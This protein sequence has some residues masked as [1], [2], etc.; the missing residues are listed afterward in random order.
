MNYKYFNMGIKV[1]VL[2]A[3]ALFF[4]AQS[5][6]A[7][8]ADTTR[9][10]EI[11]EVVVVAYG[12]QK[13]ETFVGSNVTI[14]AK[15]IEDRPITNAAKALDGAGAGIQVS[16]SSGQPGS[17]ISVRIRG[18]SSYNLSNSPLYVIDGAI[19]TGSINDL[20]PSDI[21]SL[22]VLKDAASTSLYGA[23][24]ANGIV[25][26][27][28]KSGR[29]GKSKFEFSTSTGFVSRGYKDYDRIGTKDYYE[30]QWL[31]LRNGYMD[32]LTAPVGQA[33]ANQRA[34]TNLIPTLINNV[35][36]VPNNQLVV[37]GV[38]NPNAQ[39]LFDD[40]DWY[41]YVERT[42]VI[43]KYNINYGGGDERTQYYAS[44]GYNK[45]EGYAIKSQFERYNVRVDAN[46][47]V[48]D[49]LKLGANIAA[50]TSTTLFANDSGGTS[51]I[52]PFYTARSMAPIY[53]P[54][55]YDANGQRVKDSDGNDIYDGIIT[56]GRTSGSGRNVIQETLLND[57]RTFKDVINT[58]L[59]AEFNLYKGLTL[60]TNVS[61]DL[62]NSNNKAYRNPIIGDALGTG[63]L[64]SYAYRYQTLTLNQIL[65]YVKSF[66]LH[67]IDLT[68][69]HESFGYNSSFSG[70]GRRGQIV[71]GINE[72]INFTNL[73]YGG[74]SSSDLRKESYFG[75][76]NYDYANK[77][78]VTASL[79]RDSSSR[80]A[81]DNDTGIFWSV[82]AGW[83]IANESFMNDSAFNSLK[84]R[85]SYG[86][87]G[88][89]GG[90]G[91]APG[92][93]ADLNLYNLGW[94]NASEN[95]ILI[96]QVGNKDL[97]WESNKQF[98]VAVDFGLYNNRISG[99]FEYYK[100][101]T[102]DMIFAV[103]VPMSSGIRSIYYNIGNSENEGVEATLNLGLVRSTDFTWDFSVN[104][105]HYTNKMTKMPESQSVISSGNYRIENGRSLNDFYLRQWYG[106]DS[107]DGL[108]LFVQDSE[109]TDNATT[110]TM[111]DG[112]KVTTD[113][114][115]A[116]FDYSGSAIP[117]V[118][119]SFTNRFT[120]KGFYLDALFTYQ[121]GGKLYDSNYA[122]LMSPNPNG[123]AAHVDILKSWKNPGDITDVPK[124]TTVNTVNATAA[125]SR[126]LV[127]SDY[128]SLRQ[129]TLGY[130]VNKD[131]IETIGLVGLKLFVSGENLWAKTAKKGL[132][133]IQSFNGTTS[134]RYIPSRIVSVGLNATF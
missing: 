105:S 65:N 124:L 39:L 11:E 121:W 30:T 123:S 44:M 31:S 62:Q 76:A 78:I 66:G 102:A 94:N 20:D 91:S 48:T 63:D 95:G 35:Y 46:S 99:T 86:E 50:S 58:R 45:E 75:R 67:N 108:A 131:Y 64:Y 42:G 29:K 57:D 70:V 26:I 5:A 97:K 69:G 68:A 118:Y 49:W 93:N 53:S 52:N 92:Y 2:S 12:K 110:R 134:Y 14:G 72:I 88:N 128:I 23:A 9:T 54:F 40:F 107:N 7:Q 38:L 85:A 41:K 73:V 15:E 56:R 60:R 13:K 129:A 113:Y 119:G 111:A 24:A 10:K 126:W 116:Q 115:R 43:Q 87:V 19:Y 109:L 4:I 22:N 122:S 84:L 28:T 101:A 16:T 8:Q 25:M 130:N 6:F 36:N 1:R 71:S 120:F 34:T 51:Y 18:I 3:G 106:V 83:N 117:K 81:E 125:S 104:A 37:D 103:P 98:D 74:G 33:V 21:V 79:R 61:Y 133:P 27:T 55:Y 32:H 100:R 132:E 127:S 77:Y 59:F 47:K 90:I 17:G 112:T 114:T 80:F 96:S 82:G 89:D